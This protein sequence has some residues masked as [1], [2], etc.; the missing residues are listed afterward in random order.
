MVISLS[1]FLIGSFRLALLTV[2][3][4]LSC[5]L[6]G[7]FRLAILWLSVCLNSHWFI[8]SGMT[9]VISLSCLLI[10]SF[11]L[12][13]LW[14][15]FVLSSH[16]F[17]SSRMD[18]VIMHLFLCYFVF[19]YVCGEWLALYCIVLAVSRWWRVFDLMQYC[20]IVIICTW[21]FQAEGLISP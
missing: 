9:V 16:W 2:V 8:S 15:Q 10:G 21:I 4:S 5:L 6:I 11:P 14:Y 20:D 1:W 17:I 12:A 19:S 3:F 18:V 13:L 7:S